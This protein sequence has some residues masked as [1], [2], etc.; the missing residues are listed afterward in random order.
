[1]SKR[2]LQ[3]SLLIDIILVL[4]VIFTRLR[5]ASFY[6]HKWDSV[7]FALALSDYDLAR[8]QPHP[9]GYPGYIGI[10]WIIRRF[11][12]DDNFSLVLVGIL[13]AIVLVIS[14]HHLGSL[15]WS[16]RA[17]IIAGIIALFNP[18]LWYFSDIALSYISGTAVATLAVWAAYSL[19]GRQKIWIPIIAGFSSLF[20]PYAG[21]LIA[22][23]C[24]W[25]YL[26]KSRKE[27]GEQ[28][29][30]YIFPL[31][32]FVIFIVCFFFP[33]VI[34]YIPVIYDTGGFKAYLE[35]L[36]SESGKHILQVSNWIKDPIGEFARNTESIAAFFEQAL[37]MGR[38]LFLLF[39]LP[40]PGE[41][42]SRPR[43]VI[44]ML[45]L[46][47]IGFIAA[48]WSV[49]FVIRSAG[50]LATVI[51]L[52]FLLPR[53]ERAD[54]IK[55]RLLFIWWLLPGL[56][57]F[58]FIFANYV[59]ILIIFL[60]GL[61]LLEA[62]AIERASQFMGLQTVRELEG[63]INPDDRNVQ[64]TGPDQRVE[65]LV[66]WLLCFFLA[67][68]WFGMFIS[69]ANKSQESWNGI[70]ARDDYIETVIDTIRNAPLPENEL[71]ILGG[72]DDYRHWSYYFPEARTVWTKYLLYKKIRQH[73]KVWISSNRRQELTSVPLIENSDGSLRAEIS[74]N[75]A[76][77]VISFPDEIT[78]YVG[79]DRL[80]PLGGIN[81]GSSEPLC[82]LIMT[83][84]KTKLV[85]QDGSWFL[86]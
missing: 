40:L 86:K 68:N 66:A 20:W 3:I 64:L 50:I 36:Q 44:A 60:P 29:N 74:L 35:V 69:S 17:G 72:D 52:A 73:T 8:H 81:D 80:I 46:A 61:I 56:A 82:F 21:I 18:L 43:I 54:L 26:S 77:G 6:L 37:G 63:G 45:P 39:L 32:P 38:W 7:Q 71:L 12:P 19:K 84:G 2:S 15:I 58:I 62:I 65:R 14:M 30:E 83:S 59:G 55:M 5:T 53:P 67:L 9:P 31:M 51:S 23:V 42:A 85:F 70:Q 1:M 34:A 4:V 41:K 33:I 11:I 27:H 47:I 16:A 24:F 28:D 78:K 48:H 22:P 10:A 13:S 75:D 25:L 49:D 57:L 79:D 76:R